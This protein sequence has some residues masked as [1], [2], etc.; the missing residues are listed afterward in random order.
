MIKS[1]K[2]AFVNNLKKE[3]K[4]YNSVGVLQL[5]SLPD[6]LLQKIRNEM[7]SGMKIV[8]ARKSLL[9]KALEG[10]STLE[11]LIPFIDGNVALVLSNK[12]PFELYREVGAKRLKMA[13][14]PGQIAGSDIFI[15]AG[16]TTIAP[17]QA[18]TDLKAAGIDV[19][20]QKGKVAIA[21]SKVLVPAGAKISTAV[22]KALRMLDITPFE[23]YASI[24]A[25]ISS[26]MLMTKEVLGITKEETVGN[27]VS[28]FGNAYAL[29]IAAN[30]VTPFNIKEFIRRAYVG[31]LG[32]GIT[33]NV[34]EPGV[35]EQLIAKAV[36]AALG[37]ENA[38]NI[39]A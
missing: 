16:E 14:K 39:D 28:A 5:R 1:E 24:S 23:A 31:A 12:D 10:D 26:N 25:I 6:T 20:I 15:E 22:S 2:I 30:Y 9:K 37:L 34:Y 3:V 38:G 19:Q 32:V 17:G 33:A 29:S 7:K 18:V 36:A 35:I 11:K 8:M 27:I 13:A 4:Q 21:K